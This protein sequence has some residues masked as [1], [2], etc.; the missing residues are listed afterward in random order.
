MSVKSRV[1]AVLAAATGLMAVGA[2]ANA[3][4]VGVDTRPTAIEVLNNVSVL[5]VQTC[6]LALPLGAPG[7][8]PQCAN[9]PVGDDVEE[10]ITNSHVGP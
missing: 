7:G 4:G 6:G 10:L 3:I 9:A 1:T 2:P 5:P 8:R